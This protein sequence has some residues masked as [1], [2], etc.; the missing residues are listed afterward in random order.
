MADD[1]RQPVLTASTKDTELHG[2]SSTQLAPENANAIPGGSS[3]TAGGKSQE[4]GIID[5]ARSI[6]LSDFRDV[7][8]KPC[9]RDALMTGIGT[10]F[11]AGGLRSILGGKS[12]SRP[13]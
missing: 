1:T 2:T 9:V 12:P 6:R 8:K 5:A 11:G 10:G 4:A 3:N 13:I 7:H